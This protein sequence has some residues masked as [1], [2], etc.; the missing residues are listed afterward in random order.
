MKPNTVDC[1]ENNGTHPRT[2]W[3][4]PLCLLLLVSFIV[5]GCAG[6][7]NV[8]A[9][10]ESVYP[11]SPGGG[12]VQGVGPAGYQPGFAIALGGR[13]FHHGRPTSI[14]VAPDGRNFTITNE[15]G[16]TNSGQVTG[17]REMAI[18]SL[19]ITGRVSH[20]ERRISW[21]NGTEWTRE[22]YAAGPSSTT[23][24]S[25]RW[26]HD[27]KP[28]SISVASDGR[29]F[30]MTNEVGQS[31][32]GSVEGHRKLVVSSLGIT[33]HVSHDERRISWSN[34]TEWTR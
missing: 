29:N 30:T 24:L 32:S 33:G 5:V 21:S 27:G 26:F 11:A 15:F 22:S 12:S 6:E 34:G 4:L 28:T 8:S 13:W 3:A 16:Q 20:N 23:G 31:S 9:G 1:L 17:H 25:G 7:Y 10:G 19:G 2:K 14:S 18:P